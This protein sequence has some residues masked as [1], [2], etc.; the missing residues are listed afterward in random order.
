MIRLLVISQL[1]TWALRLM[2]EHA[3]GRYDLALA[4][5]RFHED[6]SWSP[7]SYRRPK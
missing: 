2:P 7:V 4:S 5:L 1:L 3:P 6:W